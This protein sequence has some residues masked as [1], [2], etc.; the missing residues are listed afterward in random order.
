[1]HTF[2]RIAAFLVLAAGTAFAKVAHPDITPVAGIDLYGTILDDVGAPVAGVVVS[3]GFQCVAT[4]AK[5]VYQMK[6]NPKARMVYYSTPAAYVV[7]TLAKPGDKGGSAAFYAKLD[8]HAGLQRH[9]FDL[10]RLSAPERKFTLVCIGD[11]QTK[12]DEQ[13][14]RYKKE[15]IGDLRAFARASVSPCY[16]ILLGDVCG[17]AMDLHRPM[18]DATALAGIP[19]FAVIGN[20]DHDASVKGDDH[21][22]GAGFE[23]VFGP[24]NFSLNRGDVHII[25]MDDILYN[26]SKNYKSGFTDEQVEW[27]RQDL[28]FVPKDKIIVL[29]YHAPLGH[30]NA[31]NRENLMKLFEGYAEVHLM[32]GHSHNHRNTIIKKPIAAYEHVTGTAC[33]AWW[34]STLNTDGTP[35]GYG[36]FNF[37]GNKVADWFYKAN[38][39]GRDYQMRMYRGDASFGGPGGKFSYGKTANDVV[40]DVWNADSKWKIVAYENGVKAGAL[41]KLPRMVDAYAAGYHAGVLNNQR[42]GYGHVPPART[43]TSTCTP[44][45]TPTPA[46]KSARPIVSEKPTRLTNTPPTTPSPSRRVDARPAFPI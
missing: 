45:K 28:S 33:G 29:A 43:S 8:K 12:R 10:A 9:N 17:D 38:G 14:V 31:Q 32:A 35:N 11:P 18:R 44:R 34:R 6:R 3:D 1:M 16:A 37:N 46:S 27:L 22:A 4:D 20:H 15:T 2:T 24:L 13:I 5:G 36:V 25:G 40:V 41:K 30:G 42:P 21:K 39:R 19:F 23:S 7:N 26:G